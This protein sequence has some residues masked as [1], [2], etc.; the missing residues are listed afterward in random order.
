M[1]KIIAKRKAWNKGLKMSLEQRKKLSE[2]H[3]K[4]PTRYWLGKKRSFPNR[5][6]P[7]P[8]TDEHRRKI[9]EALKGRTPWNKGKSVDYSGEKHHAW[10]DGR[11]RERDQARSTDM[12][13]ANY[14]EWRRQVFKRDSWTCRVCSSKLAIKAHHIK[15]YSQFLELRYELDN[16]ITLC[17]L[18][19][20]KTLG[21]ELLFEEKLNA[22]LKNAFNSVETS[23]EAIP[24][25]QEELRKVFWACVTVRGE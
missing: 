18:C 10:I 13:H 1:K 21:K 24:S 16:G 9:S 7:I 3:L 23:Q 22:I 14:R 25:Q 8:I 20:K 4:N 12:T 11:S 2:A 19:H 5:K 6:K 17:N 15:P